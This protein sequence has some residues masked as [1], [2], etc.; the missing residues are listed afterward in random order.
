MPPKDIDE[1]RK[2]I[3]SE[4]ADELV[5]FAKKSKAEGKSPDEITAAIKQQFSK[6]IQS[7]GLTSAV[8]GGMVTGV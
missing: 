4:K 3:G 7:A 2:K 1:L 5:A 6:D 8:I